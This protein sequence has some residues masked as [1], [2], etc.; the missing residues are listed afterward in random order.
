MNVIQ[1]HTEVYHRFNQIQSCE[2]DVCSHAV[3]ENGTIHFIFYL[4]E[5]LKNA[6]GGDCFHGNYQGKEVCDGWRTVEVRSW[7]QLLGQE[8]LLVVGYLWRVY[9]VYK[10][11]FSLIVDVGTVDG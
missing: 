7:N 8:G 10:Y 4:Y 3:A 5:F 6:F 2:G 11:V 1:E 9:P